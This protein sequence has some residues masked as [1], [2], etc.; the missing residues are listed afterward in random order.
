MYVLLKCALTLAVPVYY[1]GMLLTERCGHAINHQQLTTI[2]YTSL[3]YTSPP[4]HIPSPPPP[5]THTHTHV[6]RGMLYLCHGVGEYMG[7]YEKL[8]EFLAEN[9]VLMFGHDHGRYAVYN[10]L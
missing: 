9:G 5:Q 6:T 1:L 3:P 8:G 10:V 4:L 2:S 7:R